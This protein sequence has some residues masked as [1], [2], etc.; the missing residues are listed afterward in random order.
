MDDDTGLLTGTVVLECDA[1]PIPGSSWSAE[2]EFRPLRRGFSVWQRLSSEGDTSFSF[3]RIG[4]DKRPLIW[5]RVIEWLRSPKVAG[6]SGT[7]LLS[8]ITVKGIRNHW[9][10]EL[11][12]ISWIQFENE[13]EELL[14]RLLGLPKEE[15]SLYRQLLGPLAREDV[16]SQLSEFEEALAPLDLS[17][18]PLSRVLQELQWTPDLEW[19]DVVE[20]AADLGQVYGLAAKAGLPDASIQRIALALGFEEVPS[21]DDLIVK[22]TEMAIIAESERQAYRDRQVESFLDRAPT[23]DWSKELFESCVELGGAMPARCAEHAL[24]AWARLDT[25]PACATADA[26]EDVDP[27]LRVLSWILDAF[28]SN[29]LIRFASC[30]PG[31]IRLVE[32]WLRTLHGRQAEEL[33]QRE[34]VRPN[35]MSGPFHSTQVRRAQ[36]RYDGTSRILEKVSAL[37]R[38]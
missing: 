11:C 38:G 18:A 7:D 17:R 25:K 9:V 26:N 36:A 30:H 4:A 23:K 28:A 20:R 34:S 24:I 21:F 16:R 15:I 10:A 35:F 8:A 6:L 33:K 12:A 22:L 3:K 29:V 19:E 14:D 37:N 1:S 5:L 31:E 27:S 32:E 13:C 2:V